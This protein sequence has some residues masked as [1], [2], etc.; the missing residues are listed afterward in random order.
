M[1]KW[2]CMSAVGVVFC[3]VAATVV[4]WVR[5]PVSDQELL[6]NFAKAGDF[7][8]GF[9][10]MRGL[11][12]WSPN[13]LQGTSL[14]MSWGYMFSNV[15]MLACALPF[16]YLAGSKVAVG[17]CLLCGAAGMFFF[18]RRWGAGGIGVWI[19]ALLFLLNPS[20]LTRAAGFEHFVVVVSLAALPWVFWALVGLVREGTPRAA[21]VFGV[22]FSLL[23]L[24]Y[25]KTGLM[26][27]PVIVAFGAAEYFSRPTAE[28]PGWRIW[29]IALGVVFVLA[30]L[31]NLPAL[32]EAGFVAMFEFGPFDAWQRAFST[33]SALSWFDRDGWLG[34]GMDAGFAPT[35]L[36]GGTYW[37]CVALCALALLGGALH[38]GSVGGK[39]R[40]LLALALGAFWLSFGPRSVLGGHFEFLKMSLGAEDFTPALAWFLLAVQVWM[41]FRLVPQG[42]M[43]WRMVAAGFSLVYL[44]VPG[45]RLLELVPVYRNIRAPFDFYQV[46]GAVCLIG[47]VA[48]TAGVLLAKVRWTLLRRAAAF[49]FLALAALDAIPYARPFFHERVGP[50]VWKDFL[51]A[52]EFLKSA[53]E[54][55]RVYAFSGRYFYMMTP[56][57]SGRPLAA[58]AFNSYLQQRGAAILQASAFLNDERMETYFR[59]AG[60]AY[61]LID[62]SDPDTKPDMQEKLRGIFP[63]VFENENIALLGVEKPLG[64]GFLAKDFLQTGSDEPETAIAAIGGAEHSLPMIQTHGI[65]LD[66]EG[67]S[68]KVVE[69]RIAA[70][71]GKVL[72]EGR[73]FTRATRI[74]GGN[75]QSVEFQP[76]G[77]SG[78]F[79]FN[80]AWHPDWTAREGATP[81]Q[82]HRALLAFSGVKTSGKE[83]LVFEFQPPW[84]YPACIH[85][86]LAAW[87]TLLAT[88]CVSFRTK[89]HDAT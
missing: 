7:F 33:K 79:V 13:F 83:S 81:C 89:S 44:F 59:V 22:C 87:A 19:G 66:E 17:L 26:A 52:Q 39:A 64:F 6:A 2:K 71:E 48:L 28:R 45:F 40:L 25:G 30:V 60:V 74:D 61:L 47:A 54:P 24:A 55:G 78:W 85:L 10:S 80:E 43:P 49:A 12:W 34:E 8:R 57:L 20:V 4:M 50:A 73:P 88:L 65:S 41:I 38:E 23:A 70:S 46:T 5:L 16:G 36:N 53:P 51:E 9:E 56:W 11:P 68:G 21:L 37:G 77:E 27:L 67:L 18:L 35:T 15:V 76:I 31:P 58:E 14:A 63:V 82:I 1:A 72:K 32:R 86:S 3:L 69:G 42:S 75:Y 84:W 29:G 62:K